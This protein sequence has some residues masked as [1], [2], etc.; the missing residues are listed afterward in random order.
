MPERLEQALNSLEATVGGV[1]TLIGG[2]FIQIYEMATLENV[3]NLVEF[4]LAIGGAIF[5]WYKIRGQK[6]TNES[7]KLD[8][9]KKRKEL[10]K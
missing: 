7:T 8:N 2:V 9:E 10:N 1:L 3:N 4:A 6:L 5:L